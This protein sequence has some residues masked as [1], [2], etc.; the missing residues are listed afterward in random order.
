LELHV[1]DCGPQ[2]FSR[3][4]VHDQVLLAEGVVQGAGTSGPQAVEKDVYLKMLEEHQ[5]TQVENFEPEVVRLEQLTFQLDESITVIDQFLP[6]F[7][8]RG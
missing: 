2:W 7:G 5:R 3:L 4:S 8:F 6:T 1:V